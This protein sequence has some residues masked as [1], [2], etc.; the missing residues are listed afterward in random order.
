MHCVDLGVMAEQLDGEKA[1]QLGV[2]A[3]ELRA[4]KG[5]N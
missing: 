1:E 5:L 2:S 4:V 3:T